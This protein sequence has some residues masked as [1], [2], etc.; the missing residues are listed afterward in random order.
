[1][2]LS[3][4]V[5]GIWLALAGYFVFDALAV[6]SDPGDS[7]TSITSMAVAFYCV[8]Y[9]IL[10]RFSPDLLQRVMLVISV[11]MILGY[12]LRLGVLSADASRLKAPAGAFITKGDV[13]LTLLY[14]GLATIAFWV[15]GFIAVRG[16]NR[17]DRYAI[18]ARP[19]AVYFEH[20]R[21]LITVTLTCGLFAA[22]LPSIGLVSRQQEQSTEY[23]VLFQLLPLQILTVILMGIAISNWR[24]LSLPER[25]AVLASFTLTFISDLVSGRR[26][27]AFTLL[28]MW[29][30]VVAFRSPSRHLDSRRL[31]GGALIF[32]IVIPSVFTYTV[33]FRESVD[34]GGTVLG[35]LA[36]NG[37][38][39][40]YVSVRDIAEFVTDRVGN[41]DATLRVMTF[42]PQGLD[43][44]LSGY[45]IVQSWLGR[46]TPD[47]LYS[48]TQ[49]NLGRLW[50]H[51]YDGLPRDYAHAGVWSGLGLAYGFF[52]W[53]GIAAA[54]AWGYAV[55]SLLCRWQRKP[56]LA[57]A[58]SAY[59][60]YSLLAQMIS[61]GNIDDVLAQFIA[62]LAGL[63]VLMFLLVAPSRRRVPAAQ[64]LTPPAA[65]IS[66]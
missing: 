19:D 63:G 64:R 12:T 3:T 26:G 54:A 13:L 40:D 43:Q 58:V 34:R 33:A 62:Q 47:F 27:G 50:G 28:L 59:A 61:S 18:P 30:V 4:L 39:I 14:L 49:L 29:I 55:L 15:G 7:F 46:V 42:Q 10:I 53:F 45:G 8:G 32:A 6:R 60:C 20:R 11:P 1:M 23:S 2:K 44:E 48:S 41:F 51:Y 57:G 65:R 38:P 22:T 9:W 52:G 37:A 21:P 66:T 17:A 35:A 5:K 24:R 31:A 36:G 16:R 25:S 56:L